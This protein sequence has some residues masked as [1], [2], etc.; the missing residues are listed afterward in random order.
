MSTEME[1]IGIDKFQWAMK[2]KRSNDGLGMGKKRSDEVF[3]P[4]TSER[5]PFV[6]GDKFP[7]QMVISPIH[8]T[9]TSTK[10]LNVIQ[11]S[12]PVGP[13]GPSGVNQMSWRSID[14]EGILGEC[15]VLYK[16]LHPTES[17]YKDLRLAEQLL[18]MI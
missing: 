16:E 9:S 11:S 18:D 10:S 15:I 6:E 5:T 7:E 14:V 17:A 1:K 13:V 3:T 2:R 12:L 4:T 8:L